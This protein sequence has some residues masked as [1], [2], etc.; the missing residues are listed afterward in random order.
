MIRR[1]YA[2]AGLAHWLCLLLCCCAFP[3]LA[4][5]VGIGT[6]TPTERLQVNGNLRLSGEIKPGG[7]AGQAGQVLQSNGNGTMQWNTLSNSSPGTNLGFGYWGGCNNTN[8]DEYQPVEDSIVFP[9]KSFGASTAISGNHAIVGC[10]QATINGKALAG[11]VLFYR[12]EPATGLW[13][14]NGMFTNENPQISDFFGSEVDMEGR[15]AVVT[16]NGKA[17]TVFELNTTTGL[18]QRMQQLPFFTANNPGD[19]YGGSV[20]VTESLIAVGAGQDTELGH[21]A[22]G[23][24]TMYRRSLI[25]NSWV[26][27]AKLT[28]PNPAAN[29]F[30]GTDVD[31]SGNLVLVGAPKDDEGSTNNGS[32]SLFSF[33]FFSG[34]F[35]LVTKFTSFYQSFEEEFGNSVSISGKKLIVGAQYSYV[36]QLDDDGR[37]F[38]YSVNASNTGVVLQSILSNNIGSVPNGFGWNV[39][40]SGNYALVGALNDDDGTNL[41]T[42][43]AMLYAYVQNRWTPLQKITMPFPARSS[44]IGHA[45]SIDG[46]TKRFLLGARGVNDGNGIAIFGKVK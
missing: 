20:A 1:N 15:V 28:N 25:N 45:V 29:D 12:F 7:T 21:N 22:T 9:N 26:A 42:G 38:I 36:G 39:A 4:Q 2:V 43:F 5:N 24:V 17:A 19:N 8:I 14:A 3:S 41:N 37:A 31:I 34:S 40:I 18:W 46:V 27:V 6:T 33:D 23:A 35:S 10:P 13:I 44:G 16:T 32:A 11:Y 30:F